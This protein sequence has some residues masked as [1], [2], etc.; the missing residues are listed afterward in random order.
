MR[1]GD[2]VQRDIHH[3]I[4]DNIEP[5]DAGYR[6]SADAARKDDI[7][8]DGNVLPKAVED[9]DAMQ[10]C[11]CQRKICDRLALDI[12]AVDDD[13]F[14]GDAKPVVPVPTLDRVVMDA[15]QRAN[16]QSV[17]DVIALDDDIGRGMINAVAGEMIDRIVRDHI[18]LSVRS[19]LIAADINSVENVLDLV[20]VQGQAIV[21]RGVDAVTGRNGGVDDSLIRC[22]RLPWEGASGRFDDVVFENDVIA[23]RQV[24]ENS[25]RRFRPDAVRVDGQSRK[26]DMARRSD[27][28]G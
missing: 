21:L 3:R 23:R 22:L 6:N 16:I 17:R 11:A 25:A 19:D 9:R 5:V 24:D 13:V 4:I 27:G 14:V 15:F 1:L 12:V 20:A 8:R 10:V 2:A 18:V 26:Y 7:V 28:K